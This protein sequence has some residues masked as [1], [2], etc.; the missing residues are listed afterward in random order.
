MT[1]LLCIGI[2]LIFGIPQAIVDFFFGLI[3][4]IGPDLTS[5]IGS[6]FGC[7]V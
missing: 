4:Q 5:G 6:I 1:S 3:G 7:N 2:Q